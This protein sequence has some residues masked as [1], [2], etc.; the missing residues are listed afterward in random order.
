MFLGEFLAYLG[1]RVVGQMLSCQVE[2]KGS[3]PVKLRGCVAVKKSVTKC[4]GRL[5]E[6]LGVI[7]TDTLACNQQ[8]T[9]SF[10][11]TVQI[12]ESQEPVLMVLIKQIS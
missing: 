11:R 7:D 3:L 8:T 1:E 5:L 10:D 6:N 12:F 4:C 2:R 9:T